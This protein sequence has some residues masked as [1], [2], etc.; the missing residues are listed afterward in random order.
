MELRIAVCRAARQSRHGLALGTAHGHGLQGRP[1]LVAR[2]LPGQVA[3]ALTLLE[4]EAGDGAVEPTVRRTERLR[5]GSLRGRAFVTRHDELIRLCAAGDA[6][7]AAA[8]AYDTWHSQPS[9][10]S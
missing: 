9:A 8:V 4:Q 7:R 2:E 1:E 5:F 10:E 6:E 3:G